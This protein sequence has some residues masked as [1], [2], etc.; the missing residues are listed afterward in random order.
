VV[1]HEIPTQTAGETVITPHAAFLAGPRR[2][3]RTG[4]DSAGSCR[5]QEALRFNPNYAEVRY[6]FGLPLIQ[7]GRVSGAIIQF[8][9][10]LRLNPNYTDAQNNLTK[11]LA[12]MSQKLG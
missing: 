4:P 10:A 8:K 11:A 6:N 5:L 9:E 12:V 3:W 1:S 2:A 7:K